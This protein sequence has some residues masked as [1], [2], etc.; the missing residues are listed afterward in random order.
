MLSRNV[1]VYYAWSRQQETRAPLEVIE[2]RFPTLFE[3]R[4]MRYPRFAE[5]SAPEQFEQGIAG[6]LDH[7]LKR[8]FSAFVEL[9][10]SLTGQPV[11]EIERGADDGRL[12]P[13]DAGLLG[14]A[15]TLIVI[16]FD[17]FRTAQAASNAEIEAV[18]QFL[19]APD[20]VVFVCPH[21]NIGEVSAMPQDQWLVHQVADFL[22]HGDTAIPPQQ[23]FGGFARTLLNGLGVPVENR[24]GL[25]PAARPDGTPAPL[26]VDSPL[27][28]L[29]LLRG[30]KTFNLHPHLPQLERV[31]E[32]M[33]RL[34]VLARQKIDLSAPPHPFTRD[35]RRT[36]DALLQSG[37][38]TF[39]G[40]LLV[41]D[42]TLWSSTAGG[43]DSL[44][45][46]WSNVV[47]R[48]HRS[49][50]M[51]DLGAR[52]KEFAS[53]ILDPDLA[54]PTGLVDP[55]GEPSTLRFAVYR[56][57]VIAGLVET[58]KAAFPVVRRLVGEPFFSAMARVYASLEPPTSPIMLHYGAGF[59][60]FIGRFEP[61]ASL[62]YLPDIA[63]LEQA[64]VQAYHAAES[65]PLDLMGFTKIA[66]VDVPRLCLLLHP[67]LRL[68]RSEFAIVTIWR[69][70]LAD[71]IPAAVEMNGN[72]QNALL[73]R[74][75]AEVEVRVLQ[76]G[77]GAFIQALADGL[78]IIEAA[79]SALNESRAFD[80]NAALAALLS[81]QAIVGWSLPEG[82]FH[83][84]LK[85]PK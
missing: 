79:K 15:D 51:G 13:I 19:E 45:R 3:S 52:Q 44:R 84:R 83:S 16:S 36:F 20:N 61:A 67:S 10:R 47:G 71:G 46:F 31:G 77:V 69:M 33:N 22:H 12:P 30:V 38:E 68:V 37:Q 72:G 65:A 54:L 75:A 48:P 62:P 66:P 27:D 7:I 49:G 43:T 80:L 1:I 81:A 73:L 60:D 50:T 32:A 59:A 18:R 40:T 8:N 53:A 21:H 56:N 78:P 29:H 6:F 57:N 35:G 14:S 9:A 82:R 2:N 5:L 58:L 42:T 70:N 63:R 76:N 34:Q 17:S 4:R 23:Q 26:E 24:F 55:D 74:P 11:V 39:A 28:R 64:W 25:R 41:G 85:E